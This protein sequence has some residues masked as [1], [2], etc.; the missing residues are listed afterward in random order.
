M[1][2]VRAEAGG[3]GPRKEDLAEGVEAGRRR[4]QPRLAVDVDEDEVRRDLEVLGRTCP[5]SVPVARGIVFFLSSMTRAK[6][7]CQMGR[8]AAA[9]VCL[10]PS[11]TCLSFPTQTPA[12]SVG[13]KPMNQASEYLSVVPVFPAR[14]QLRTPAAAPVPS[15]TTPCMR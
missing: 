3:L 11:E 14:G 1:V 9:P 12:Q 8:A 15:L 13:E 6:K 4:Q 10:S 2:G 7:S 5:P